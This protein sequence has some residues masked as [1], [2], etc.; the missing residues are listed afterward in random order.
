[1]VLVGLLALTVG[2]VGGQT[3]KFMTAGVFGL[4]KKTSQSNGNIWYL[5]RRV[6]Q[7]VK[8]LGGMQ[9]VCLLN[10][11]ELIKLLLIKA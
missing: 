9:V 6:V 8:P 2:L 4:H 3:F 1:V 5:S 11:F 10:H 7:V